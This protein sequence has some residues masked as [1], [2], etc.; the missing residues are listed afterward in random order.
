[1]DEVVWA[2]NPRNDT[3]ESM[4][5]YFNK[6]VQEYLNRAGVRCR[7]D[8]PLELPLVPLSAEARH[9]LYLACKEALN[10]V[11]KHSGASE[12]WIRLQAGDGGFVLSVED[13]G[14]G[15]DP[16]GQTHGNGLHNM[17]QRLEKLGGL[18][19]IH[20]K[21]GAG[22]RILFQVTSAGRSHTIENSMTR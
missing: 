21:P 6:F 13:N 5:T 7:M 17:Q 16:H 4:L 20:S 18:C 12:V 15:F 2:V 14:R 19:E 8:V 10:N 1:M 9:H 3:L 11:V 22:T